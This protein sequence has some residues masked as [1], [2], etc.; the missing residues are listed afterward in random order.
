MLG[1]RD[2]FAG[3]LASTPLANLA[4]AVANPYLVSARL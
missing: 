3:A 4:S 2:I 1:Q